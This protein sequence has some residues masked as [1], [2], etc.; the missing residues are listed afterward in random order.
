MAG[1]V[2]FLSARM[3]KAG[4]SHDRPEKSDI[5]QEIRQNASI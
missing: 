3:K 4:R 5:G 2:L 1:R